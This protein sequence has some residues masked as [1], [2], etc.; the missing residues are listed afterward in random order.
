MQDLTNEQW[1][2]ALRTRFR[3]ETGSRRPVRFPSDRYIRIS[4]NTQHVRLHLNSAAILANM[5]TNQSAFEAWAL[6]LMRWCDVERVELAWD[7]TTIPAHAPHY[8]RFLYR[9]RHFG[10]LLGNRFILADPQK[11]ADLRLDRTTN[12]HINRASVRK[13]GKFVPFP[14]SE[15]EIEVYLAHPGSAFRAYL[16]DEHGLFRLDRQFPVGVFAG[17]PQRGRELFTAATSAIDLIGRDRNDG[18][19]IF[20]LK[21]PENLPMGGLSEMFF[22]SLVVRDLSEGRIQFI[23]EPP[24]NA[25]AIAPRDLAGAKRIHVR[26]AATAFHP[27]IDEKL[28]AYLNGDRANLAG[29]NS[30]DASAD[31]S[32]KP[33]PGRCDQAGAGAPRTPID[34]ALFDLSPFLPKPIS[35]TP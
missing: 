26:L 29:A 34:Y 14:S 6:A 10:E 16:E 1:T 4:G 17:T 25:G 8:Q 35:R 9:A 20:E 12:A 2:Q 11:F 13:P 18:L 32:S 22:Y 3:N 21:K 33:P 5:Q 15:T 28:I 24:A 30:Q 23:D 31:Q 7:S 27:L 19:W